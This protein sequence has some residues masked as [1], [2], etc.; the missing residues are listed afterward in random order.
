MKLSI[1]PTLNWWNGAARPLIQR[2]IER[3]IETKRIVRTFFFI[4]NFSLTYLTAFEKILSPSASG[5]ESIL[6]HSGC[7]VPLMKTSG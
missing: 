4:Y 5:I 2:M 7:W 3:N 1:I 6:V